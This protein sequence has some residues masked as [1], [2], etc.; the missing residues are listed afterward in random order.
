MIHNTLFKI[1][2][3]LA[4]HDGT[5]SIAPHPDTACKLRCVVKAGGEMAAV[6]FDCTEHKD[7]VKL[8]L[9]QVCDALQAHLEGE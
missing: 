9:G 4:R 8:F 2:M 3:F 6:E 1:F 7:V 5:I